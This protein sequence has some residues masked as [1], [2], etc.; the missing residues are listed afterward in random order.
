[1]H[2]ATAEPTS[3]LGSL[4]E[5]WRRHESVV[6]IAREL[7]DELLAGS[8]PFVGRALPQDL[9]RGRLPWPIRSAWVFV[10][11]PKTRNPA[12]VHPNSIQYTAVIEGG[13]RCT[14]GDREIELEPFDPERFGRTL[15]VFPAGA[16]HSFEPDSRPLVVLSFHTSTAE[17]LLE[18]EVDSGESRRYDR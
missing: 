18:I 5:E 7:T 4:I 9:V 16:A 13:G 6:A 10:L 8:A 17:D 12:H 11:R 14:A 3:S 1:M 2:G 15:L